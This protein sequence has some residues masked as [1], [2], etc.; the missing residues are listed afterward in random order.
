[1]PASL[2]IP[3]LT[4]ESV[5]RTPAGTRLGML[6][7]AVL[8]IAVPIQPGHGQSPGDIEVARGRLDDLRSD[9]DAISNRLRE[10]ERERGG[11]QSELRESELQLAEL[12]R[13]M[14][15]TRTEIVQT[16]AQLSSLAD[17]QTVLE[18]AVESQRDAVAGELRSLWQGGNRDELR[19]LLSEENPQQL[20]R[21]LAYYRYVLD[22][23]GEILRDYGNTLDQLIAIRESARQRQ[24]QLDDALAKLEG[25]EDALERSSESRRQL[26]VKI[27]GELAGGA[28]ELAARQRDQ[29]ELEALIEQLENAIA[30]LI[31]EADVEAF[32]TAKGSM[33]WPVDGELV[34]RFG[35]PRNQG[36][37]RWQGV[38]LRADVGSV[39]SAVHHG[40]V[41]FADWLRGSGLLLVLDHG[42][43]YL[44]LYAHNDSLLR[45]VGDWVSTGAAIATVGNSG[46]QEDSGLYF[47]IRK[48][49]KPTDP[50]NW[51]GG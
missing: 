47:E 20:A 46:G 23:R 9:I 29:G 30:Q 42:E 18:Q 36:K 33:P 50:L 15:S 41:V 22:A 21:T 31:T 8:L 51:V 48:D 10:K 1:M 11:L 17:E 25:Q 34:N 2:M 5:M 19:L 14:A 27:E 26:L 35:R 39:V 43:G 7:A 13:T 28:Q 4:S 44:S 45:D 24:R 6:V 49:G 12:R 38:S 40:R 37:M 3:G 32:S 16:E